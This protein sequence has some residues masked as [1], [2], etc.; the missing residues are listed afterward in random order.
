MNGWSRKLRLCAAL[1]CAVMC[2]GLLA[3]CGNITVM[4]GETVAC[5]AVSGNKSDT[6]ALTGAL[7]LDFSDADDARIE[8]NRFDLEYEI[9][10]PVRCVIRY[11]SANGKDVKEEFF[12]SE[13]QNSFSQLIDGYLEGEQAQ[14]LKS[15]AVEPLLEGECT[16]QMSSIS[17]AVQE[18]LPEVLTIENDHYE[19]GVDLSMGG[20]VSRL[21]DKKSP[22]GDI[23]NLLNRHDTGRLIQQSYYGVESYEG[24]ENGNYGN[25]VWPYNPVQGG[26]LYNNCSKIVAVSATKDT[27][28]VV[29]RPLDWAKDGVYTYAYYTNTY[30]LQEDLVRVD[31]T[32]IDF[33]GY[34]NP[35]RHQELPAFY[36]VS[37]LNNFVFYNGTQPWSGDVLTYERELAFWGGNPDAYFTLSPDNT[38]TWCAWVD[39]S[40][41]GVGLY[42]PNVELLL[43][44]RHKYNGDTRSNADPTNYVA[45]V[46]TLSLPCYE[47]LSYSYLVGAGTVE[48]LRDAFTVNRDFADNAD[49]RRTMDETA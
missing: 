40:D 15:I 3:G 6:Y 35:S 20:G 22:R 8:F 17:L 31:N 32:V 39:D 21:V 16:L 30:T 48:E 36:T 11:E 38:E 7:T 29:S 9:S 23:E 10:A 18:V 47:P 12:L 24:Y 27:V 42:T 34:P 49:L 43:A 26:D 1:L 44:G 25:N 2:V 37:A 28:T 4:P 45:P 19:L 33:S 41:Y 13:T 5:S 14:R 46:C